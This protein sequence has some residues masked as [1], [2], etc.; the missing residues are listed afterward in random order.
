MK[1]FELGQKRIQLTE[2]HLIFDTKEISLKK[3]Q[4]VLYSGKTTKVNESTE[5][6]NFIIMAVLA[7]LALYSYSNSY[8]YVDF[9]GSLTRSTGWMGLWL[10]FLFFS[11][12]FGIYLRMFISAEKK[13]LKNDHV[14]LKINVDT[15]ELTQEFTVCSATFNEIKALA[16]AIEYEMEKLKLG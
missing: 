16:D 12:A 6:I 15:G 10:F 1:T 9:D 3:I 13:D 11:V 5:R 2:R 14:E 7:I 8:E 4:K